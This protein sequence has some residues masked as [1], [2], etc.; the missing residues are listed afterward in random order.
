MKEVALPFMYSFTASCTIGFFLLVSFTGNNSTADPVVRNDP[1]RKTCRILSERETQKLTNDTSMRQFRIDFHIWRTYRCSDDSGV[2][3]LFLTENNDSIT[4]AGDTLN[5]KIRAVC[6]REK[7]TGKKLAW[8][9]DDH[10]VYT[11]SGMERNICFWTRFCAMEDQDGDGLADPILVYGTD[12]PFF[13][14]DRRVKIFLYHHNNRVALR[15][16]DSEIDSR[17]HL[18]VDSAFYTLPAKL[19]DRAEQI[20]QDMEK[21]GVASFPGGWESSLEK[22]VIHIR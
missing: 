9:L 13:S 8:E 22:K 1:G 15:Y 19:Q 2:F 12:G 3:Y 20:M 5:S 7:E 6:I 16:Q 18:Q 17:K 10:T 14:C 21:A 11:T 4:P